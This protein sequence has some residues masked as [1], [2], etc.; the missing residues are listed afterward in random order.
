MWVYRGKCDRGLEQPLALPSAARMAHHIRGVAAMLASPPPSACLLPTACLLPAHCL[1]IA[2]CLPTAYCLPAA[3]SLPTACP[4]PTACLLPA[5]RAGP[6]L[7]INLLRWWAWHS[8]AG[9]HYHC[10][11]HS[12]EKHMGAF[13]M[14]LL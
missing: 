10:F 2:H 13:S 11:M 7:R 5:C 3:C 1:L 8:S 6:A 4:L 14:K 12:Q 9:W